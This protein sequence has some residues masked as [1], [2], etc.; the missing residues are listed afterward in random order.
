MFEQLIEEL[1]QFEEIEAIALGG[2]RAKG[3][4]DQR[5]DYDVYIYLQKPLDVSKRE[6]VLKKYCQ[7]IELANRFWEEEDNALLNSGIYIDL[8]YRNLDDFQKQIEQT[9]LFHQAS[10]GYTTC[11]WENLESAQILF[12]RYGRL[13]EVQ[14]RFHLPYPS[15]LKE[16]IKERQKAL[17]FGKIPNYYDQIKK[18]I[19]RG[20][21][22]AINHRTS[23]FMESYFD[24]LFGMNE[25]RHPGEK[26]LISYVLASCSWLP[27]DFEANL[28]AYFQN[29]YTNPKQALVILNAIIEEARVCFDL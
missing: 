3:E 7:R 19:E 16:Q 21:L 20:D 13:K 12:D 22:V 10:N 18:A 26:R 11:M 27:K 17:L 4:F 28:N 14:E 29:L 15:P 1:S 9:V 25:V 8:V 2:S 24:L 23:A 5:S 6:R